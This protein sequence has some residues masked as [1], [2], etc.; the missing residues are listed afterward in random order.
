MRYFDKN[1]KHNFVDKNN[2]LV[3]YDSS[4]DCCEHASWYLSTIE[5]VDRED[6]NTID[7]KTLEDYIFDPTYF[8]EESGEQFDS[9]GLVRFKLVA[10]DKPDVFLH[11]FNAHNGYYSHGFNMLKDTE[12]IRDGCL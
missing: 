5:R 2:V 11:L 6:Y 7:P 9:G 3:G 12:V 10:P 4:Q 1:G 8:A